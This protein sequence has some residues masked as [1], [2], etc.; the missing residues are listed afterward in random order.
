MC[1]PIIH[2]CNV[3]KFA[4][5]QH[6]HELLHYYI[7]FCKTLSNFS[8]RIK[9]TKFCNVLKRF[10]IILIVNKKTC[11]RKCHIVKVIYDQ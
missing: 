10:L 3:S 2:I 6:L 4:F 1:K 5:M 7:S 11:V 9:F 8:E